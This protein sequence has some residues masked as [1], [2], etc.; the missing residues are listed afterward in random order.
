MNRLQQLMKSLETCL[1][2]GRELVYATRASAMPNCFGA[3]RP[4]CTVNPGS[5]EADWMGTRNEESWSGQSTPE[6]VFYQ[7]VL[8]S[9]MPPESKLSA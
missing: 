1:Y 6:A 7:A 8:R 2:H 9:C 5:A 4:T 3:Q